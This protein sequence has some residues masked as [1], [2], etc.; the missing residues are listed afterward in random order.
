MEEPLAVSEIVKRDYLS[1]QIKAGGRWFTCNPYGEAAKQL[2]EGD[3][4]FLS[5]DGLIIRAPYGRIDVE[6]N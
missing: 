5:E 4:V 6:G 3:T 2:K 1:M